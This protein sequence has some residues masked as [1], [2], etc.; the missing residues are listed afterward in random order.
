MQLFSARM[1]VTFGVVCASLAQ[2]GFSALWSVFVL[3]CNRVCLVGYNTFCYLLKSSL[4]VTVWAD[5]VASLCGLRSFKPR[6]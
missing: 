5:C 1:G 3:K 4:C 2:R 6:V